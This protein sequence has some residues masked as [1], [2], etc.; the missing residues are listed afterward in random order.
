MSQV[1]VS[2]APSSM[3]PVASARE[4][5]DRC[6]V[7]LLGA[8][9]DLA[10]RKLVGA[11]ADLVK[12]GLMAPEYLIVGVDRNPMSD[13][14]YRKI[15]KES[16]D[17]SIEVKI[18]DAVWQRMRE[19]I[20]YVGADL[21]SLDAYTALQARLLDLEETTPVEQRNRL[22][23]L[24][25]PPSIFGP[26]VKN[27]S[28]SEIAPKTADPAVRPWVR[29]IVEKPFG[30][31]LGSA[32]ELND[33]IL[34]H[35]REHQVF[36]IDHY[37]GKETVQN[38]L[39]MRSANAIFEPLWNRQ[40]VSHVQ[41]TAA[42]T[43]GVEGRGGYYDH[44][45]VVRDMFQ[46]HLLQ[47]VALTA[48]ELPTT[49][50][51]NDVRDEKVKVLRA[52]RPLVQKGKASGV[53][54]QYAAGTLGGKALPGYREE[55]GVPA[56]TTTP[57]YSAIKVMIDNGRW[58]GVPFFVR[59]GKRMQRRVTEIAVHFKVP[60]YLIDGLCGPT[61]ALPVEPNVLVLRVQPDDGVSLR[62]EA[63]IPGA[64]L[65]LTPEIEVASVDMNFNYADAFGAETHPAYET[66]LLDCMVGEATLFTR[67]DEVEVGWRITDPLLDFWH[68][69]GSEELASYPAGS[70]G[71]AEADALIAAEGFKWRP[72]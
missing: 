45:G 68:R 41:I 9:G 47:L 11:L 26:I 64:A 19:R 55:Q 33:L 69:R 25:V 70:A 57:T 31:S 21:T 22:V 5:G 49:M 66:L 3:V 28:A 51:A 72:F 46:N 1:K 67:T 56:T 54:A 24:S 71:P 16:L 44:V 6:T 14:D 32:T 38:I 52:V 27:L 8:N 42:E 37:L 48:M 29:V 63:K 43:V 65:S 60:P 4:H 12:K 15:C 39:V 17:Q 7:V 23:Y 18:D 34:A 10:K 13:E 20:F 59:S 2:I 53:R 50:K 40:F 35:F 61:P 30:T 58:R 62:F 36:R